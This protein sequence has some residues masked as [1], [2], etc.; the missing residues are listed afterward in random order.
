MVSICAVGVPNTKII[1]DETEN[2]IACCVFP[3]ARCQWARFVP[4]G[5]KNRNK[6]LDLDEPVV[7]EGCQIVL[8]GDGIG[9]IQMGSRMYL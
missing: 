9:S 3:K 7:E 2:N 1:N 8:L 4:V 5:L 6:F